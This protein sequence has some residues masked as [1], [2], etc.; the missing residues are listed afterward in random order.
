MNEQGE[1]VFVVLSLSVH[2]ESLEN[3]INIFRVI[4]SVFEIA[5]FKELAYSSI[6]RRLK[7]TQETLASKLGS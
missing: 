4:F 2:V 1:N 6:N 3:L 7:N 5:D